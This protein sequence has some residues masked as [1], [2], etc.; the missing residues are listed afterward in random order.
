MITTR[1]NPSVNGPLHIGHIFSLLVNE[2][3]AHDNGGKFIVRFDDTSVA[4]QVIPEERRMKILGEQRKIID[5]LDVEVDGWQIQSEVVPDIHTKML[6]KWS[7]I[8]DDINIELPYFVR[9]G[10]TWLPYPYQAWQT[11]ER[12]LLDN[13]IGITHVIR[14][15]EFSTEYSLYR[16]MCEVFE[17]PAPH[18]IFIPRLMS[19]FGDI[20]K[21]NGGYTIAELKGKGYSAQELKDLIA[22]AVLNWPTYGWHFHNMKPNPRIDL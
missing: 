6:M 1:L 7:P 18:F 2:H 5:W 17:I 4:T 12:V 10:T 14:G 15:E 3:Y 8:M 9:M 22:D 19:K 16:Y 11:A 13:M 21:T 20:S